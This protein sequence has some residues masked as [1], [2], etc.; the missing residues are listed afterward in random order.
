MTCSSDSIGA[1]SRRW[2]HTPLVLPVLPEDFAGSLVYPCRSLD[3]SLTNRLP[4]ELKAQIRS[5]AKEFEAFRKHSLGH[6]VRCVDNRRAR[7]Q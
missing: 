6:I 2:R 5:G 1:A 3:N 7:S 4:S